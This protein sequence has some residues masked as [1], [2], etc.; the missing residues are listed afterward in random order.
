ML[1][2]AVLKRRLLQWRET[3]VSFCFYIFTYI[4][5]R[6]CIGLLRSLAARRSVS[7]KYLARERARFWR[8]TRHKIC[9]VGNV[10]PSQTEP[11]SLL[12]TEDKNESQ[13]AKWH[14]I[15]FQNGFQSVYINANVGT[16]SC[17]LFFRSC[18]IF[19]CHKRRFRSN[20]QLKLA[21]L[22]S[23]TRNFKLCGLK[24]ERQT[25]TTSRSNIHA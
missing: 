14:F 10:L 7:S 1:I 11:M 6:Y 13:T 2:F 12:G 18:R 24:I 4:S 3:E 19:V 17:Q 5:R 21:N 25:R 8:P 9:H 15:L 20:A 23:C 22:K 16:T